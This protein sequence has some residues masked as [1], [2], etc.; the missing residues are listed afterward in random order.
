LRAVGRP[1]KSETLGFVAA[2]KGG[3]GCSLDPSSGRPERRASARPL[4]KPRGPNFF[5]HLSVR[6]GPRVQSPPLHGVAPVIGEIPLSLLYSESF[7]CI[8]DV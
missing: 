3:G 2:Q 1:Y 6:P 4:A 7:L 8:C 5:A